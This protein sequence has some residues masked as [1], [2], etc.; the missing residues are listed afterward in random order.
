MKSKVVTV[1]VLLTAFMGGCNRPGTDDRL[2]KIGAWQLTI[3]DYEFVS[4]SAQYK[5]L[6]PEQLQDRLVEDGRILAYALE[7]HY[8]TMGMLQLQLDYAMRYYAS[9]VNGY[10]WNKKVKPLLQ[11]QSHIQEELLLGLQEKY[12]RESQQQILLETKPQMQEEAI[13]EITAKVE[14]KERKWPGVDPNKVLMEY[15]FGGAHRT[16]TVANFIEFVHCQPMFTGSLSN[17]GDVKKMLQAHL[18][19][20]HGVMRSIQ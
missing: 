17:P 11:K 6:T 15:E 13:A 2:L 19:G 3:A 9:S 10:V 7:H 20:I 16:Y 8:D 12:I 14:V 4:N 1:L 18:I 5:T